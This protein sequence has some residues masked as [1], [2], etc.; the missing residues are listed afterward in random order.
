MWSIIITLVSLYLILDIVIAN[1]AAK[2]AEEK[3][4]SY[5]VW[6]YMSLFLG[7]IAWISIAAMYDPGNMAATVEKLN[8]TI[9]LQTDEIKKLHTE[10]SYQKQKYDSTK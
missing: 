5:D 1:Y 3:G 9:T 7:V 2:K 4:R 8:K 6:F 10:L